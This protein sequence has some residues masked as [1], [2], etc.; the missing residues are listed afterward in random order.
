MCIIANNLLLHSVFSN[1]SLLCNVPGYVLSRVFLI[2]VNQIKPNWYRSNFSYVDKSSTL[3]VHFAFFAFFIC[4]LFQLHL[5]KSFYLISAYYLHTNGD[6][7]DVFKIK[8][9]VEWWI[10]LCKNCFLNVVLSNKMY[11]YLNLWNIH[12]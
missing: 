12:V 11:I 1:S 2:K 8:T 9:N 5:S 3:T 7:Y 4:S 10:L 6:I